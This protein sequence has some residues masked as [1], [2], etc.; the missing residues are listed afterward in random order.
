M[1]R[2]AAHPH[3]VFFEHA[4]PGQGFAR[5]EQCAVRIV[6]RLHVAAHQRGNAGEVLHRIERGA[7]RGQQGAGIAL[8][9]HQV[10]ARRDLR[11]V[12]DQLLDRAVGVERAEERRCDRQS[13]HADRIAAVHH[14]GELCIRRDDGFGGHVA[15]AAGQPFAQILRQRCAHE[16]IEVEAGKSEIAHWQI[17]VIASGPGPRD[18][19]WHHGLL[20]RSAPRNDDLSGQC[21]KRAT[22]SR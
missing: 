22:T 1:V 10:G 12:L 6:H 19:P 18:N 20:R 16:G 2:A 8:D 11:A 17:F 4:Q 5:V 9:P 21:T 7:L 13:R 3:R 15:P 14:P